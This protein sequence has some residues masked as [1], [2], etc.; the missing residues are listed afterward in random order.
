M[1]LSAAVV[2]GCSTD[3]DGDA[4]P[5]DASPTSSPTT[6]AAPS[7]PEPVA[8]FPNT[9]AGQQSRW[10]LDQLDEESGPDADEAAERFSDLFLDEVPAEEVAAT[11]DSLRTLGPFTPVSYSGE[12]HQAVVDLIAADD[13]CYQLSVGIDDDE[14]IG[15]L[16]MQPTADAPDVASWDEL[17]AALAETGAE[18]A[19]YAARDDDGAWM[20]VHESSADASRPLGS[21]FK[22]YV[23]GAVQRA[24]LDGEVSWDDEVTVTSELRSL[25]S[26]ELQDAADGTA[27][28]VA[29][30]AE[31]MISISDNTATDML[32]DLVGR[33][34]VEAAVTQMGHHEPSQLQPFLTTSEFFRLGWTE[35][36][37]PDMWADSNVEQRRSLLEDLPPDISAVDVAAVGTEPRWPS[38]IEWFASAEDIAAA[39][40]SLQQLAAQD[41]TQTLRDLMSVNS[42]LAV[43][44]DDWPYIAFKGGSSAGVLAYSWYL[45][46]ADGT[47]H[48]LVVQ[49][50]SEDPDMIAD[51]AHVGAVVQQAFDLLA[52]SQ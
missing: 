41:E 13:T 29:E 39:H 44:A 25:P 31:K 40:R 33:E 9:P 35:P 52:G 5:T 32:I 37:L 36:E 14:T 46:D 10:V 17:D 48:V 19:V 47:G 12:S 42:G 7:E 23:L 26:G 51:Q 34:A 15:G 3:D 38:G 45:E 2:A 30:A 8:E 16:Y 6:Q 18:I 4:G 11:F 49:L 20:P 50:S 22:L 24:V 21:M 43:D 28:T 1:L 27:V